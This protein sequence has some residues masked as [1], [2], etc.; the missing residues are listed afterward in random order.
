MIRNESITADLNK[1]PE[2]HR[3][4]TFVERTEVFCNSCLGFFF[5]LCC[6]PCYFCSLNK[7]CNY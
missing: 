7:K 5:L 4:K 3:Q 1:L 2:F 6:V